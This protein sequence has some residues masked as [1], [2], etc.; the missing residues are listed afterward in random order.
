MRVHEGQGV[1]WTR[2]WQYNVPLNFHSFSVP[3]GSL[4]KLTARPHPSRFPILWTGL[5]T[6]LFP[7]PLPAAPSNCPLSNSTCG[8][9][10]LYTRDLGVSGQR[11]IPG[12]PPG[13][14]ESESQLVGHVVWFLFS[15]KF[16][17]CC[18]SSPAH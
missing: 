6:C 13:P 8:L 17:N 7:S 4:Q 14:S 9:R 10:T 11:W 5:L 15:L 1:S 12:L 18:S 16:E 3:F 2:A